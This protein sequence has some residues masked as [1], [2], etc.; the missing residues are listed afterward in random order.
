MIVGGGIAGLRAAWEAAR[1]GL[2]VAVISKTHPLHS[3]SVLAGDGL[4]VAAGAE[5]WAKR[6][7]ETLDAG[8]GLADRIGVEQLCQA[9]PAV[10]Q[11]LEALGCFCINDGLASGR[12]VQRTLYEQCAAD[13]RQ[14]S[15]RVRFFNEFLVLNL[16]K[17]R[18]CC[19]GCVALDIRSGSLHGFAARSVL[20]ATG[21]C[22]QLFG[23]TT[24][25]RTATG[26]GIAL[27]LK[28][29]APVKDMEFI[30]FHPLV[31]NGT[32]LPVPMTVLT[33][34]GELL[35]SRRERFMKE[36]GAELDAG[37]VSFIIQ[38]ELN[39]GRGVN[40]EYVWLDLRSL[41]RE[42]IPERFAALRQAALD[43]LGLDP[44]DA[45]LPVNPGA[46][47]AS[48]GVAVDVDGATP[49]I[50]LYAAGET[51]GV[52]LHGAG[53]IAGNP[54]LEALVFGKQAATTIVGILP[55]L[56]Q[57]EPEVIEQALKSELEH[58]SE[59]LSR[60]SREKA[61]LLR[62]DLRMTMYEMFGARRDGKG[63]S[64]GAGIIASLRERVSRVAVTDR[65]SH[66]NY[67]LVSV[68][69]LEMMLLVAEAIA[70]AAQ[71]REESRGAHRRTDY[72]CRD[73][74]LWRLHSMV[75]N[76]GTGL[77]VLYQPVE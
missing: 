41:G 48:G 36:Y 73:D 40:G 13:D 18:G 44:A 74:Q 57:P 3:D 5:L 46:C 29:G 51:A 61:S 19:A 12:Q 8:D 10:L 75:W 52:G 21:G 59:V 20:L 26:D 24:G 50:G 30:Q 69:E 49:V 11:E 71:A 39:Q 42:C 32:S 22:G 33:E 6:T 43:F 2:Q 23:Q 31:L 68:L 58:I 54:L 14:S 67:A 55:H 45:L 70:A 16:V 63:M 34:G 38:R 53:C 17:E 56:P 60:Q 65:S 62:S 7:A 77:E 1:A 35:N 4:P 66:Y 72:P 27:A 28:I 64:E 76:D 9:A 15:G 47:F 37:A 25:G